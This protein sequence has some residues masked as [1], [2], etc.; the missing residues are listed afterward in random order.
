MKIKFLPLILIFAAMVSCG[1][2]GDNPD[3]S[4][5]LAKPE[6]DNQKISYAIATMIANQI[7]AD[8]IDL[9]YDYFLLGLKNVIEGDSL[10]LSQEEMQEVMNKHQQ[11]VMES[12]KA[13]MLEDQKKMQMA[14]SVNKERGPKFLEENKKKPGVKVSASG[15]QFEA[16]K[17]G[18]GKTPAK[19]EMIK[20]NIKGMFIDGT[21]FDDSEQRQKG[22]I[23]IPVSAPGLFLGLI[24][25]F[26]MMK[27]G[28]KYRLVLP[29][30]IGSGKEARP[31]FPA[32]AVLIFEVELLE[33]TGKAPA[34]NQ[35]P[36]MQQAPPPPPG[37]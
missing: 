34:M 28:G 19:D 37:N 12:Q 32:N 33:I 16:L 20:V 11:K 36:G 26:Q 1:N 24:E 6:K 27:E 7:K 25:G 30:E 4:A 21:V 18:S 31:P 29:P 35:Q 13:K 3:Q 17:E 9:D 15:L 5:D 23:E 10:M 22:G 8:S 2:S 14:D